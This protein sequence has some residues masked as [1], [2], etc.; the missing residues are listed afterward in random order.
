MDVRSA[1]ARLGAR[2]PSHGNQLTSTWRLTVAVLQ[3]SWLAAL[4]TICTLKLPSAVVPG[5]RSPYAA[6]VPVM[7]KS[8]AGQPSFGVPGAVATA[9]AK[10]W[11]PL[12]LFFTWK[13]TGSIG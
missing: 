13:A 2:R 10:F 3:A 11:W 6:V 1:S 8:A 9:F 5:A 7:A 12:S 4:L